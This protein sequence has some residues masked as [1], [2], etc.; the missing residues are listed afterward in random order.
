MTSPIPTPFTVG[1]RVWSSGPGVD[2]HGNPVQSWA[3]PVSVPV[4]AVG[5]RLQDGDREPEDT[6]RAA[7]VEGLN[8]YAPA[9]TTIGAHD[10]VVWGGVEYEVDGDAQDWTKGPWPNP[11]A[12]VVFTLTRVEG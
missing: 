3:A 2:R 4:H 5:P 10:R 9:G 12:G 1:V 7:V 11:A 6:R 8:V